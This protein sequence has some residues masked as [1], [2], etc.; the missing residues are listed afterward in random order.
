MMFA[1][2]ER[3]ASLGWRDFPFRIDVVPEI[4]AGEQRIIGPLIRQLRTGSIVIIEGGPGTGKT[5][6][7][8]YLLHKLRSSESFLPCLISEPMDTKILSRVLTNLVSR[9][10]AQETGPP[11]TL[12]D[13]LAEM[14][15][16]FCETRRIRIVLLVDEAQTL[17][18]HKGD[19]DEVVAEKRKTVQW[20]RVL[21]DLPGV[22]VFLAGLSGFGRALT[23]IFT[24]LGE[25]VTLRMSL[26][27]GG[28]HGPEVL[29]REETRELIQRRIE[30]VEGAG[31]APF[32]EDA[33]DAIHQHTRGYPRSTLRLCESI[34]SV[35]F[36]ENVPGGDR[37]TGDFVRQVIRQR[38]S[39][40]KEA[41]LVP[42]PTD[43]TR[44]MEEVEEV[45]GDE[46]GDELTAI[47]RDILALVKKLRKVTSAVVAEE[48]GIAKGTASNEL[49]KLYD[50]RKLRRRKSYRGF[51]YLPN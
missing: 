11:P 5:H 50:M 20:L 32:T 46:E 27:R 2:D 9:N 6:V 48:L 22:V 51:E 16:S 8:R 3:M 10:T 19:P 31:I 1:F 43:Y 23:N 24:P 18:P 33:I 44:F 36:Q 28:R 12:I 29:T 13:D 15:R 38:P 21:S 47:Q 40:P 35:A 34:L 4:I 45:W 37:I 7:L 14:M 41:A 49:K 30:F 42:S 25:R 39:P 17:A 26:E